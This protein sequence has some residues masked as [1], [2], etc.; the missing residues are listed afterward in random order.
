ML[1]IG[2]FC[3]PAIDYQKG[4]TALYCASNLGALSVAELL[5]ASGA[6]PNVVAAVGILTAG[7]V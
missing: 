4:W 2:L 5:L 6:D 1:S 3:K 7:K